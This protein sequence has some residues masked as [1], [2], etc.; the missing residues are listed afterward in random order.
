M[1]D[2]ERLELLTIGN[3]HPTLERAKEEFSL[4]FIL[5][6]TSLMTDLGIS[7]LR[8]DERSLAVDSNL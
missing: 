8:K 5:R 2:H 4:S 7:H 1:W 6:V 3:S